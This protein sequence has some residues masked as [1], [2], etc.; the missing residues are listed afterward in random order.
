MGVVA[1]WLQ[2]GPELGKVLLEMEC[3]EL[4]GSKQGRISMRVLSQY[5]TVLFWLYREMRVAKT[6]LRKEMEMAA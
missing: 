4:C 3:Q 2:V 5:S 6:I 1:A